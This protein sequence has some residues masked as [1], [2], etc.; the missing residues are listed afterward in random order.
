MAEDP[1]PPEGGAGGP[2]GE[3]AKLIQDIEALKLQLAAKDADVAKLE[4]IKAE[5]VEA[6]NE[7][8]K[9]QAEALAEQ[10]KYKELYETET[11]EAAKIREQLEAEKKKREEYEAKLVELE[12]GRKAELLESLPESEREKFKHLSVGDLVNLVAALNN[13]P[14]AHKGAPARPHNAGNKKKYSEMSPE[15]RTAFIESASE[16]EIAEAMRP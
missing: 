5:L 11:V 1:K 9:R 10:G 4:G 6:R 8:K 12:N 14:G 7:L 2:D 13:K 3:T 16:E 15:E